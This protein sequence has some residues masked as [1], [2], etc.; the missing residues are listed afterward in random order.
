MHATKSMFY[1]CTSDIRKL[2][3]AFDTFNLIMLIEHNERHSSSIAFSLAVQN[4][5]TLFPIVL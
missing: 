4:L 1:D 3:F 5:A 2:K